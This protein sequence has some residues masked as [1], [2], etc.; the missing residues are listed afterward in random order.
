MFATVCFLVIT[1]PPQALPIC[2]TPGELLINSEN[3]S[4][5][6]QINGKWLWLPFERKKKKKTCSTLSSSDITRC[7]RPLIQ[8]TLGESLLE[9]QR[10][11]HSGFMDVTPSETESASNCFAL[12]PLRTLPKSKQFA[13]L[14]QLLLCSFFFIARAW[15]QDWSERQHRHRVD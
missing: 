9:E 10:R 13:A 12:G 8:K 2:L 3:I 4:L 14:M 7:Q 11:L 5:L 15:Q 6:M 1:Y